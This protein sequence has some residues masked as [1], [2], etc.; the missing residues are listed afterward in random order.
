MIRKIAGSSLCD[1]SRV[2]SPFLLF[3]RRRRLPALGPYPSAAD[4]P[5]G[6]SDPG[7]SRRFCRTEGFLHY[8]KAQFSQPLEGCCLALSERETQSPTGRCPAGVGSS[9]TLQRGGRPVVCHGEPSKG[10]RWHEHGGLRGQSPHTEGGSAS[11]APSTGVAGGLDSATILE[12][13]A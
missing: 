2:L 3:Q 11:V 10:L 5:R 1:R 6:K 8:T 7:L 12:V 4:S 9:Q 13:S